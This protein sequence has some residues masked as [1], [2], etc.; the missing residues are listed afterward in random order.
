M[1]TIILF[2]GIFHIIHSPILIIIPF[3]IKSNIFDIIYILYFFSIM[4]LYTFINGECPIS[5]ISKTIMDSNYIAGN[6]I[7]HYPEMSYIL[8]HTLAFEDQNRIDF[9]F[10]IMT[11]AYILTLLFVIYRTN[12]SFYIFIIPFLVLFLYFLFIRK[13]ITNHSKY[14]ILMQEITK[15]ILFITISILLSFLYFCF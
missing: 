14:F 2:L 1:N 13:F 9:Y 7:T 11:I 3:L 8:L 4:F 10:G 15:C 5:Y 6:N 12:M